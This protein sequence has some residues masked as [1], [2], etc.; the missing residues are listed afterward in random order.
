MP[1]KYLEMK[2]CERF[3]WTIED[4][5]N[6]PVDR[7]NEFLTMWDVESGVSKAETEADQ[8]A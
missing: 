7:I 8:N 1:T 2:L 5:D 3:G 4:L 6:T